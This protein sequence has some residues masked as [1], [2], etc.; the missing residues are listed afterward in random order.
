MDWATFI[1]LSHII[2]TVIGV[3]ATTFAQVFYFKFLSQ[4]DNPLAGEVLGLFYKMIRLG[5]VILIFSG[6]GY[7]VMWRLRMLGPEVFFSDRFLSKMTVFLVL[8]LVAFG[9]NF[10]LINP[11]LGS[12]VSFASWY[13]VMILGIWRRVPYPYAVIILGYAGVCILVYYV[14]EYLAKRAKVQK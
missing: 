12:A 3:G 2:G 13:V 6:F 14:F 7:L 8:L 11:K 1:K 4:K 10:R 5:T 9:L